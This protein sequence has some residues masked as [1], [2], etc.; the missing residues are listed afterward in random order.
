VGVL[1]QRFL[2]HLPSVGTPANAIS[3]E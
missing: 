2:G 3:V 1:E